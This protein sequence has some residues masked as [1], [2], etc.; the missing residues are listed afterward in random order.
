MTC[1]GG[2]CLV[3]QLLQQGSDPVGTLT[4]DHLV[5]VLE[6]DGR[7]VA[8][9][10]SPTPFAW[11]PSLCS[12]GI[13]RSRSALAQSDSLRS[14]GSTGPDSA[15]A[16][17]RPPPAHRRLCRGTLGH[18]RAQTNLAGW[19]GTR[20][21][22]RRHVGP[23][24][25]SPRARLEADRREGAASQPD[26]YPELHRPA[27]SFLEPPGDEGRMPCEARH[28]LTASPSPAKSTSNA[29]PPN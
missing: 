4:G 1:H 5:G 13:R 10:C 23:V 14:G 11:M 29:S 21:K 9:R 24:R 12:S 27:V 15:A 25:R 6:A 16:G 8:S 3:S 26:G 19:A 20:T 22:G 28:A 17:S 2:D 18:G 7:D